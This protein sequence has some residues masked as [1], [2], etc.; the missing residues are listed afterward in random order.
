MQLKLEC[1]Y[2]ISSNIILKPFGNSQDTLHNKVPSFV[3]LGV[4]VNVVRMWESLLILQPR[5]AG[6]ICWVL[7]DFC[8]L[9]FPLSSVHEIFMCSVVPAS[10]TFSLVF[11]ERVFWSRLAVHSPMK[12]S[13]SVSN[14]DT[15]R[16]IS[17]RE[18]WKRNVDSELISRIPINFTHSSIALM[19][20]QIYVTLTMPL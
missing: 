3:V 20:E 1:Y 12:I 7:E 5:M 16:N 11:C 14:G 4:K 8:Q 13:Q 18:I 15:L 6:L 17:L 10:D 2:H 9:H 19:F